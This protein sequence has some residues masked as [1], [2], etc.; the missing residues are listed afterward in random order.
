[1]L[2]TLLFQVLAYTLINQILFYPY[3]TLMDILNILQGFVQFN[4]II[5]ELWLLRIY[6]L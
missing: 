2:K 4:A 1:M 5:L 6:Y 3:Y